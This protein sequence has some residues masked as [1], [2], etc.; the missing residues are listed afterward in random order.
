MVPMAPPLPSIKSFLVADQ[1]FQQAGSGKWCLI[2]VF[3]A[4]LAVSY[5][6]IHPSLGLY[7]KLA[8]AEGNYK[9]SVEFHDSSGRCLSPLPAIEVRVADRL[10]EGG[11]GLQTSNLMIP[12]PGRY[13][14][15]LFFN[16]EAAV[17]DIP[18]E[19]KLLEA[20][21]K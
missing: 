6:V 3:D 7:F 20:S 19:A 4:I 12:A 10:K 2:G 8:D 11:L 5:P 15:K 16:G 13:F 1:V 14:F 9:L 18:I 17:T 21:S